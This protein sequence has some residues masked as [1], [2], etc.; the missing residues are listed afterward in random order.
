M[1]TNDDFSVRLGDWLREDSRGRVPAHL[2]AVL[3][4][5]AA[6]RQRRWWSSPR[7]W[8]PM[9]LTASRA[10]AVRPT[11][12]RTVLILG[13]VAI[14]IAALVAVLVGSRRPL[15]PP[16]GPARNGV[17]LASSNGDVFTVDPK[18]GDTR[19]LITG[20]AFDFGPSFSRDGTRLAIA[21]VAPKPCGKPDCGLI[22]VVGNADGSGLKEITPGEPGLDWSDWSP[23]GSQ[24][25]FLSRPPGSA[26][27][28]INIINV[29][30]SGLTTLS[31]PLSAN[32]LSWL[33][34]S[35]AEI[36][37]RGEHTLNKDLPTGIWAV[38]PDGSGLRAISTRPARDPHDFNDVAVSPDGRLV[39]Y[40]AVA[41]NQPFR[42]HIL[43]LQTGIEVPLPSAPGSN[44]EGGPGF[45]PDGHSLV[46]L[47]W[48]DDG[49]T[50]LVVAPLDGSSFGT[51][52]GPRSPFGT[53]GPSINNYG[54]TPDGAA[55]LANYD[56][57][58]VARLL[59]IDGSPGVII[60]RGDLALGSFQRLAP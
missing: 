44:G 46:Y 60:A 50:Q 16:F 40:R 52:I 9:D 13:L 5:T 26:G 47:R 29:D 20:D 49:S 10:W 12:L 41:P 23:T 34:P 59:P 35:G 31:L 32:Q 56:A 17:L 42:I 24:I 7:R 28:L 36:L 14:L 53:D 4:R 51:L 3:V 33:P 11:S 1:T 8:L 18:T 2:D 15:P 27:H 38:R 37:F 54:F 39:A 19:P 30:G 22:I 21:R 6:T 48:F 25:T 43:D 58:K 45:S 57:E 55:V